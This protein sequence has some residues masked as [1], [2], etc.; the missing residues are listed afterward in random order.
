MASAVEHSHAKLLESYERELTTSRGLSPATVRNYLADLIPFTEYLTTQDLSLGDDAKGLR[1]FIQRDGERHVAG[2]YRGL[3]RDYV[4]WL[5][6]KRRLSSGKRRGARGHQRGSVTRTLVALRSFIRYLIDHHRLP[7]SEVWSPR[8]TLMRR[9]TPRPEQRLPDV[10]SAQDAA[11]LVEAPSDIPEG[12]GPVQRAGRR[13]DRALLELLY[14]C[15]LRVSE[16]TGLNMGDVA[17]R[18]ARVWGK[19]SKAR[20]V[21]LG[22]QAEE[23]LNVYVKNA[24]P[25]LAGEASGGA[26]FLN[27]RGGRL[28]PRTVQGMVRKYAMAAGI[29]DGVHPHTLRHSFATHLLDGGADLRVVQELLGHST[30]SATQV[31]THVSQAE[32][33]RVYLAAHPFARNADNDHPTG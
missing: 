31:Y 16:V 8:S 11:L 3:V 26:L 12:V 29:H 24:R 5:M 10:V 9:F 32:A 1:R 33:R 17:S 19:G 23:A 28:T 13:R 25:L 18:T 21:P 27:Q 30:P 2:E 4:A 15:G 20:M 14:G 22:R 6:E 7:G